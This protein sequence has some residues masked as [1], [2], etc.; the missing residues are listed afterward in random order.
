VGDKAI[1]AV[2]AIALGCSGP[3]ALPSGAAS[4][5]AASAGAASAGA[6]SAGAAGS[7]G[8]AA[9]D[10]SQA[11]TWTACGTIPSTEVPSLIE[12][13]R[14]EAIVGGHPRSAP[15]DAVNRISALAMNAD[16]GTLVSMGGVTLV[17]D[18]APAFADSR[19]TYVD[20]ATP[21]WPRVE[22]SPDGRWIAIFGDGRRLVSRDGMLG[23]S[24]Y[25]G[26]TF[27]ECWP[28]E[29]RFSP[30]GQWLVGAGFGPAIDVFR[31][32]DFDV[33]PSAEVQPVHSVAARCR[34][35]EAHETLYASTSRIAFTPDG[36]RLETETGAQFSTDDWRLVREGH[37]E[38][39][40]HGLDGSLELS[41]RGAALVSDC[42]YEKAIDG[43]SCSPEP[44]RF[45]RFSADGSWLLAA[46]TLRHV[47][48][49][50]TRVL[51]A[52]AAVGIFAPNGDVI[53]ASADN[54]LTRYCKT[55]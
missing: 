35:I 43:Y 50:E 18:V 36:Q 44:G 7:A 4:A 22:V 33:A 8:A 54:S 13:N 38:P 51:D 31:V 34:S 40:Q 11:W 1:L 30:D 5:G 9:A 39:A 25:A 47:A 28:A 3:P 16:G 21:E 55:E 37:G 2:V 26:S 19:A 12:Y 6:A 29:A 23:P 42:H 45:P 32:A 10:A 46:G 14:G 15:L 53:T 52:S 20:R 24:I 48:S 17:W 41:A 27:A 49:G